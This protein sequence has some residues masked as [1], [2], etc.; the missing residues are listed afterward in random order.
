MWMLVSPEEYVP[1][2]LYIHVCGGDDGR[3]GVAV[4]G[5]EASGKGGA[6]S[7][8]GCPIAAPDEK[9]KTRLQSLL[10]PW[11]RPHSARYRLG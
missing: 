4:I 6:S 2:A 8:G 11:G 9:L 5:E 1:K 7:S 3:E 10:V